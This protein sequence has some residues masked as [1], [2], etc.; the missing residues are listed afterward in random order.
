M[1]DLDVNM[2]AEVRRVQQAIHDRACAIL[3]RLTDCETI[4]QSVAQDG[5]SWQLSP[6]AREYRALLCEWWSLPAGPTQ[7]A[8]YGFTIDGYR[9]GDVALGRLG[10]RFRQRCLTKAA[11]DRIVHRCNCAGIAGDGK[12]IGPC[13]CGATSKFRPTRAE[14]AAVQGRLL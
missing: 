14:R 3:T 1:P 10:R 11:D 5:E 8:L 4:A 13:T 12:P 6:V 7:Q 2:R 9:N